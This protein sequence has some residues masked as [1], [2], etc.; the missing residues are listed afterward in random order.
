[1]KA[2]ETPGFVELQCNLLADHFPN[3]ISTD[4]TLVGAAGKNIQRLGLT[5]LKE[6]AYR[7]LTRPNARSETAGAS[8]AQATAKPRA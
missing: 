3:C 2:T 4:L 5:N 8:G 6:A 7:P 1:M